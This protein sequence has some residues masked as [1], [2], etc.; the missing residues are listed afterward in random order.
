MNTLQLIEFYLIRYFCIALLVL[1][2]FGNTLNICIFTRPKL[3][4]IPC[5]WYFLASTCA[6]FIAIYKGCLTRVLTT[7]GVNPQATLARILPMVVYLYQ[8][9]L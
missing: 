8:S 9:G 7:F 3:R 4:S 2:T 1:G 6:N 5:S